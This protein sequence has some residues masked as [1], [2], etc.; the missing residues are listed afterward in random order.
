MS[1][2]KSTKTHVDIEKGHMESALYLTMNATHLF[3][4][5]LISLIIGD[6]NQEFL[7]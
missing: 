6:K 2:A 7:S 1:L 5:P 4:K 3:L